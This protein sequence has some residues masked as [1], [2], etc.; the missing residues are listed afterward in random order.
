[1][2]ITISSSN[3]QQFWIPPAANVAA[4][5]NCDTSK[6][7]SKRTKKKKN[8]N[9]NN[10]EEEVEV[11]VN[12][13]QISYIKECKSQAVKLAGLG[14]PVPIV[15]DPDPISINPYKD[16]PNIFH[17][18]YVKKV[19]VKAPH[20]QFPGIKLICKDCRTNLRPKEFASNP[21]ARLC[22]GVNEDSYIVHYNYYCSRCEKKVSSSELELDDYT[23]SR[24]GIC[25]NKRLLDI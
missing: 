8:G 13:Y 5:D 11:I 9:D 2:S 10:N 17:Y 3:H 25:Y 23:S 24:Y 19:I 21:I 16:E 4:N 7:K 22:H 1:M 6:E 18:G 20:L 12:E 15:F 14:K